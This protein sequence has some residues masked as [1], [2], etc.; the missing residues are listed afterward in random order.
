MP[1]SIYP[2]YSKEF[3]VIERV[4]PK[5]IGKMPI[6]NQTQPEIIRRV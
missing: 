2:S 3:R 6:E 4:L 1:W 5:N